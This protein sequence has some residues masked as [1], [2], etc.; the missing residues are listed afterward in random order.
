[1]A[2]AAQRQRELAVRAALGAGKAQLIRQLL[3]ESTL[4]ALAGGALGLLV[5]HWGVS[6]MLALAPADLPRAAG[7]RLDWQV[8]SFTFVL[9]LYLPVPEARYSDARTGAFYDEL[10]RRMEALPGVRRAAVIA[11]LPMTDSSSDTVF[12][13]QGRPFDTNLMMDADIK[14]TSAG[15]FELM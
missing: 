3:T 8:L 15:W 1:I 2:R 11:P 13:V 10:L 7:A 5:A 14:T 12:H 4:L 9:A 6:A